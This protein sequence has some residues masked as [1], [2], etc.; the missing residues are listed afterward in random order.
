MH[1]TIKIFMFLCLSIFIFADN[2]NAMHPNQIGKIQTVHT[3]CRFGDYIITPICSGYIATRKC[4]RHTEPE[5]VL[6]WLIRSSKDTVLIDAGMNVGRGFFPAYMQGLINYRYQFFTTC[7][8]PVAYALNQLNV[9]I[10]SVKYILLTHAHFDHIGE[11]AEFKE[12]KVIISKTEYV[13]ATSAVSFWNGYVPGN[14]PS[15]LNYIKVK[16]DQSLSFKP[17]QPNEIIPGLFF[18]N[19][20]EHTQGHLM[21]VLKQDDK[22]MLFTGDERYDLPGKESQFRKNVL[23]LVSHKDCVLLCNH[24]NLAIEK[25]DRFCHFIS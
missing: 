12:S 18:F 14:L 17:K 9:P 1:W 25:L 22:Y 23:N 13:Q 10:S 19:T 8:R 5:I 7:E 4:C 24:D 16:D 2:S 6:A 3:S 20:K 15:F 21:F 11:L